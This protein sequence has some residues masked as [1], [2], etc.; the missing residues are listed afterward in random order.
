QREWLRVTLA[1]IGDGVITTDSEGRVTFLNSV[2]ESLTGWR[3]EQAAGR[4][5]TQVFSILS[6]NTRRPVDDPV[7]K[8]IQ[9]GT[10]IGLGNHTILVTKDGKNLP[11][12]DSAAPIQDQKG[13]VAGVVVVFRDVT[14]RRQAERAARF[15]A[16]IVESSD[17]AII[18][19][20]V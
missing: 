3:Q 10:V 9:Q 6:E 17:D 20:D 8:V 7:G 2:A 11:I 12:D 19:K 14:E 5:F 18:G 15:L 16:S 4:P 13:N 1:S